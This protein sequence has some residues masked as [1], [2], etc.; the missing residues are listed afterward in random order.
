MFWFLP[1][2]PQALL[3][4]NGPALTSES[5]GRPS[6]NSSGHVPNDP[7]WEAVATRI[8]FGLPV[9]LPCPLISKDSSQFALIKTQSCTAT[10]W[11]HCTALRS[12]PDYL[13]R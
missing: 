1:L 2:E 5:P 8:E 4:A 3:P 13:L 12:L 10:P 7:I 6:V 9:N 11:L